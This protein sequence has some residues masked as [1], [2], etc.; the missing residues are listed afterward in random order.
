MTN[1][2]LLVA[3]VDTHKD[4]HYTAVITVTGE[5]IGAAEFPATDDGYRA[6]TG[7]I[8]CHG[9]LLRTGVEG[10]N[11][12]GAGLT[13]HL[14]NVG[15][16]VVEVIRPARQVRRMRG[17]F[18]PL[19]AYTAAHTALANNN[20]VTAKTSNG[21]V[22]AIRVT[23]AARRSAM[24]ARTEVIVQL[25][26]LIVT[27]P[28][29]V[30]D[31]YRNLTTGALIPKLSGSRGRAGGDEIEAHTRSALKRLA[32][33]YQQLNEEIATYDTDLAQ[34][35]DVINPA[36]V[37]TKGIAMLCGA[38]PLPASSGKTTRHRLN[39]GGDRAANSALHKIAIVRMAT[40]PDT[41]N[42]VTRRTAEGK[43]KKDI[44]RC[45]KRAIAR[46]VF[47]LITD[48]QPVAETGDLR[49]T[50]KNLGLTLAKAADALD[51][52]L[53]T[54]DCSLLTAHCSLLTAEDLPHRTR[55]CRRQ[56]IRHHI[57]DLAQRANTRSN[58]RLTAIGA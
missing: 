12:Y 52:S 19:D 7:F 55:T 23:N 22:E 49:P 10:T 41:R 6:L 18:D 28:E 57:P 45:L 35:V 44:L 34:L 42:Y 16:E 46:E 27:A 32:I 33:R 1:Q 25:K 37:Q 48:P 20:T 58:G 29:A 31:E 38:A 47:H 39:R 11:S 2:P 43:T 15:I 40:D 54:A 30:R 4:T 56:Q 13:R 8:T 26:S 9:A 21:T 53:L 50:R 24:K 14:H 17:K 36:L 3:G 51:C 5:H